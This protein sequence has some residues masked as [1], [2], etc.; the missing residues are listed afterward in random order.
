VVSVCTEKKIKRKGTGAE[1]YLLLLK[2]KIR[3]IEFHFSRGDLPWSIY[4]SGSRLKR[5]RNGNEECNSISLS[6]ASVSMDKVHPPLPLT[7]NLRL[8]M[9]IHHGRFFQFGSQVNQTNFPLHHAFDSHLRK[10]FN[11]NSSECERKG[12]CA[13]T[14]V[15]IILQHVR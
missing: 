12:C 4:I 11:H 3:Y 9:Y 1:P 14:F 5:K 8:G 13:S 7:F 2:P 10:L 6:S 15:M